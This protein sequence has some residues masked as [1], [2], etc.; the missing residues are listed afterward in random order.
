MG[1]S[2][3]GYRQ[4]L[5]SCHTQCAVMVHTVMCQAFK[6]FNHLQR[7]E[8][9]ARVIVTPKNSEA[10]KDALHTKMHVHGLF[11]S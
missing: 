8:K 4:C 10:G 2:L 5:V 7:V 1:L 9:V 3:W 11:H 6:I